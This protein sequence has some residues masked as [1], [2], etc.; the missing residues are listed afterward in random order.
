[1]FFFLGLGQNIVLNLRLFMKC[2]MLVWKLFMR[3]RGH[4]PVLCPNGKE[5][6]HK[7]LSISRTSFVRGINRHWVFSF[8]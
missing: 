7:S 6:G 3:K 2:H 5:L 8:F 4:T 1:M